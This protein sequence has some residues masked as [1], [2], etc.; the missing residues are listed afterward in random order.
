M[1]QRYDFLAVPVVDTEERLVG[2]VTVDDLIDVIEEETTE[3]IYA[4]GGVQ[5]GGDSYFQ[6]N[7]VDVARKRVL[8]LSILLVTN[9]V[10]TA[11]IRS[12]QDIFR[13]GGS[14]GRPSFPC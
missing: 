14:T 3:D 5:A 4:L 10:T 12:Q 9:T 2:I 8:W 6:T 11:V 13:A 1:V 7:L